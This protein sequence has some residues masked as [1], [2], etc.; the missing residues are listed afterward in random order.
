MT[1]QNVDGIILGIIKYYLFLYYTES[2]RF[3]KTTIAI[4]KFNTDVF[5]NLSVS[6][7]VYIIACL[8]EILYCTIFDY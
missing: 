5:R 6:A 2:S 4:R 1:D 3:H 7:S 8:C